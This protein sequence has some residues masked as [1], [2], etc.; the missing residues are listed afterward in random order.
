[1]K[2]HYV[3]R[4]EEIFK[5]RKRGKWKTFIVKEKRS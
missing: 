4:H 5:K 2:K 1:M 3:K